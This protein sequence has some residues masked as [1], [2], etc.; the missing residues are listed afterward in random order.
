METLC[1]Q[2]KKVKGIENFITKQTKPIKFPS[3]SRSIL[4]N[5]KDGKLTS[6]DTNWEST[7]SP[8]KGLLS[9]DQQWRWQACKNR[10]S[11]VKF[12]LL[13]NQ[14][15]L[16]KEKKERRKKP[17]GNVYKRLGFYLVSFCWKM[18]GSCDH[19]NNFDRKFSN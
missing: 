6:T 2:A 15:N 8:H 16:I 11:H 10:I 19:Q 7:K 14:E 13:N 3:F 18:R 17:S 5:Q 12:N 1:E 9:V 4:S